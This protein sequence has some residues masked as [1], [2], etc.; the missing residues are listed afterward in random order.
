MIKTIGIVSLSGGVLGEDFI[1]F[2]LEL[3]EDRLKRDFG[4]CFKYMTNAR[5][6][7]KF[8]AE[9]PEEKAADLKEAFLDPEVDLIWTA[10][11][12][13]DTFRT[14]P[15]LMNS[16]FQKIVENNPKPFLGFSDTTNNHLML[17]KMGLKTFYAPSLLSDVAEL[18]PEILPYTKYWLDLLLGEYSKPIKILPSQTWYDSRTSYTEDQLGVPRISHPE[19][20]GFEFLY[21]HKT[22]C[23]ELLGGCLESLAEMITGGR[24]EDQLEI[25]SRF[26]IFPNEKDWKDKI[27]FL[28][29]SEERPTPEK[30]LAMIDALESRDVFRQAKGLIIGKP[31]NEVYYEEYREIFQNLA[32]RY[33]LPTVYNLNF[34]HAAPRLVLPYGRKMKINFTKCEITL[35]HGLMG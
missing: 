23:G 7:E 9:H 18:G 28:E 3:M 30:V 6:G 26:E 11:G 22:I 15:F 34:G 2:E 25:Y 33:N 29:T 24:Y 21:G 32:E 12:G 31:Q 5:R 8:L 17:Y 14:I 19:T 27:I 10:L 20:H 35:P 13:D 16:E 1:K 4:L